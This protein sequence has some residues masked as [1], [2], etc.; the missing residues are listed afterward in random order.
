MH[1][2]ASKNNDSSTRLRSL[3]AYSSRP[4]TG[5]CRP[6]SARPPPRPRLALLPHSLGESSFSSRLGL[7]RSNNGSS[8]QL[9]SRPAHNSKPRTGA[10]NPSSARL[11]ACPVRLLLRDNPPIGSSLPAHPLAPP[12]QPRPRRGRATPSQTLTPSRHPRKSARC[13]TY[14]PAG[15]ALCVFVPPSEIILSVVLQIRSWAW[16]SLWLEIVVPMPL[17]AGIAWSWGV[18]YFW[19]S[20]IRGTATWVC[21]SM[22]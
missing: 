10:N 4:R 11:P 18:P 13:W 16:L 8:T 7:G 17:A 2:R 19:K 6:S 22:S 14:V 20:H 1:G 12:R 15:C 21:T 9:R 3:L 5:A